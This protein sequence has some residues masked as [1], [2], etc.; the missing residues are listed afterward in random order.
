MM[1]IFYVHLPR[2]VQC[3]PGK[4]LVMSVSCLIHSL[5]DYCR[6]VRRKDLL[7]SPV[8]ALTLNNK[9]QISKTWSHIFINSSF[10]Q[11]L[12]SLKEL[13][14]FLLVR[15][16]IAVSLLQSFYNIF[17]YYFLLYC[18]N[19]VISMQGPWLSIQCLCHVFAELVV[20]SACIVDQ[21]KGFNKFMREKKWLQHFKINIR[22]GFPVQCAI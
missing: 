10:L 16:A 19:I 15:Y 3:T 11:F 9:Q 17:I 5:S 8:R 14:K 18:C 6:S 2:L 22:F 1:D 20:T 4:T 13:F 7:F 12:F 21:L